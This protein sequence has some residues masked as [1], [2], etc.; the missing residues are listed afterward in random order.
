MDNL[1]L[2][3]EL[4]GYIKAYD[5]ADYPAINEAYNVVYCVN[6]NSETILAALRTPAPAPVGGDVV[7]ALKDVLASLVATHSLLSRSPKTAAPSNKMFDQ[8]LKDYK[9]SIERG[10]KAYTA[11]QSPPAAIRAGGEA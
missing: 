7:E 8:M 6:E 1:A 4:E 9:K 10:R 3:D 5:D 2:A 11:I